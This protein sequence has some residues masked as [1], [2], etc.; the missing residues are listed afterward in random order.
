MTA[1]GGATARPGFGSAEQ[2]EMDR[3]PLIV[4][5]CLSMANDAAMDLMSSTEIVDEMFIARN[6]ER[7][8]KKACNDGRMEDAQSLIR[9]MTMQAKETRESAGRWKRE[10]DTV[11]EGCFRGVPCPR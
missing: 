1:E 9:G 8:A 10:K 7:Y 5:E 3:I 6:L 2:A 11:P 4:N